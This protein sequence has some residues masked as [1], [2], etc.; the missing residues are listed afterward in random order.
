MNRFLEVPLLANIAKIG[1]YF[2][3]GMT[4]L[5]IY[6]GCSITSGPTVPPPMTGT[7]TVYLGFGA[8]SQQPYQC[9]GSGNVTI[10]VAGQSLGPTQSYVFSGFSGSSAPACNT[11]NTFSNLSPGLWTIVVN[12]VNVCQRQVA[13]GNIATATIRI[14]NGSCV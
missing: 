7:L 13:A 11:S 10:V 9:T 12:N 6:A 3:C 1:L 8:G 5:I 2:A 4:A 14:E